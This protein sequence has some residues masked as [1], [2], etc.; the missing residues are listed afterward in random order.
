MEMEDRKSFE[1]RVDAIDY[2]FNMKKGFHPTPCPELI[3]DGNGRWHWVI[4]IAPYNSEP[5]KYVRI[6]GDVR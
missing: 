2:A 5:K 4:V 6:D 3:D 1:T